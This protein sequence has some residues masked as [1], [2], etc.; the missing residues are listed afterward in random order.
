[1]SASGCRSSERVQ[2]AGDAQTV[3]ELPRQTERLRKH[4]KAHPRLS[5]RSHQLAEVDE[6]EGDSPSVTE[7]A[8]DCES[9][10]VPGLRGGGISQV[11][12][13]VAK[14]AQRHRDVGGIVQPFE[15]RECLLTHH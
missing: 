7:P 5:L 4:P 15:D 9:T 10:F 12:G 1:M 3:A 6:R 11:P 8:E 14:M 13:D 2:N